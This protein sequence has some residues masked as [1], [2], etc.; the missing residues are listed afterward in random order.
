MLSLP[1]VLLCIGPVV[2]AIGFWLD[3]DSDLR[4]DDDTELV[5]AAT[6]AT[7]GGVASLGG[8]SSALGGYGGVYY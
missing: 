6:L 7:L 2:L 5:F 1:S 8:Y 3:T 4:G